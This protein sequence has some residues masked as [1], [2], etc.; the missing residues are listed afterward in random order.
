MA[1]GV[2][3]VDIDEDVSCADL[4][5]FG[6]KHMLLCISHRLGRRYYI[7]EW[8]RERFHPDF[9]GQMSWAHNG[10]FAPRSMLDGEGR[11]IMWA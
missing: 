10:F 7:G 8:K 4:F 5:A 2:E 6:E 3:G 11:R 9:R 1:H